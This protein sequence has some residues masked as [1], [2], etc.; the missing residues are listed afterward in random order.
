MVI[1][2]TNLFYVPNE[3]F[4]KIKIGSNIRLIDLYNIKVKEKN[5]EI[6]MDYYTIRDLSFWQDII[7]PIGI[8]ILFTGLYIFFKNVN[9]KLKIL[10]E[11]KPEQFHYAYKNI[12][13]I[14]KNE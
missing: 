8:L 14:K 10:I 2:T 5:N 12:D 9:D 11:T 1:K 6:I 3:D 4:K 13:I 7:L